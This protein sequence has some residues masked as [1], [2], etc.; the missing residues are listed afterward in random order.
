MFSFK[1]QVV[2]KCTFVY[3]FTNSCP[4]FKFVHQGGFADIEYPNEELFEEYDS[5]VAL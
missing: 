4:Y 3:F 1:P 2:L 5:V